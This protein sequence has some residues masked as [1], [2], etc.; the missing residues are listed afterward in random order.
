MRI[1]FV[2]LGAAVLLQGCSSRPR[3]FAPTLAMAPADQS[4][5]AADYAE[6]RELMVA[7][8][9]DSSGRLGS[10]ATGAGAVVTVGALGGAAAS[11]AGMYAGAALASATIV[12]LP[13]VALGGAY[14]MAKA[15]QRRKEA[16]IQR[17]MTGC[18]DQRGYKVAAW[19]RAR[20]SDTAAAKQ[21]AR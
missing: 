11:S 21:G 3:D 16:A 17:V 18:L 5:F 10:A 8:K 4:K 2:A 19:K 15:K 1:I 6:C 12:A 20:P 9:L 14:G 7:G 13:F